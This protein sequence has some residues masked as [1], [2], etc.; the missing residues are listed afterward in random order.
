M[1]IGGIASGID[2]DA[3]V[4]DLMQAERKPLERV[5]QNKTRTEWQRDAYRSINT[6]LTRLRDT[7]FNLRLQSTYISRTASSTNDAAVSAVASGRSQLGSFTIDKVE[8][9]ASRAHVVSVEGPGAAERFAANTG[10][11]GLAVS[12]QGIDGE[13][14]VIE[15]GPEA[16][17]ADFADAIN[18]NDN[19]DLTL[20]HDV[21]ADRIS[22]STAGTG[23]SS[24]IAFLYGEAGAGASENGRIFLGDIL[25]LEFSDEDETVI[26]A[27]GENAVLS[28]NGISTEREGNTFEVLGT[29]VTLN[30]IAETPIRVD[31][32]QDTEKAMETIRDF[33]DLYNE[34]IGE[35]HEK[36]RE[37]HHRDFPPLTDEQR[38][39]MSEREVELWEEKAM[40]GVLRNDT[41][42]N[43]IMSSMRL[44]L[45]SAVSRDQDIQMLSQIGI[46]TGPWH[47]NGRLH[48]DE[49]KLQNALEN[50]VDQVIN[51][52]TAESDSESS[53]GVA[54]KLHGAV[55]AG[56]NRIVQTAGRESTL[57]DQS[58]LGNQIRR[59]EE[60]LL[61]M[62]ERLARVEQRYWNQF[63]AM[64]RMV[65]EMNSQAD[66]LHQ[67]LM[68]MSGQ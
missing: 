54:R 43:S 4:R 19:L 37:P 6:K 39:S 46:T 10:E 35:I 66:W 18:R 63:T 30:S 33:V 14:V 24:K 12:L 60:R 38:E 44:A 2:T 36:L 9:L 68:A 67:Q 45:G 52:F 23:E 11:A 3:L 42:L 56:M 20:Y 17:F 53:Q 16:T 22:L 27:T 25:G 13:E 48:L 5:F 61:T 29:S 62:E 58:Y 50:D 26:A 55:T 51:L 21:E 65:N 32:S 64:E 8:R 34:I 7:A 1:R 40:S 57:Y 49:A 47:E 28:I 41:T 15:V 59:Y 31:V